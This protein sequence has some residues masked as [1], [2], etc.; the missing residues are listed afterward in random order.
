[1]GIMG[2]WLGDVFASFIPFV[3]GGIYFLTG[4]W[5]HR[6]LAIET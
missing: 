5:K 1:M 4:I 6:K 3:I 2:F